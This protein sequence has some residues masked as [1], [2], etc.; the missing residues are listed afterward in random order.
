MNHK[1]LIWEPKYTTASFQFKCYV[2]AGVI[3]D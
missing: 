2:G 3:C 1:M